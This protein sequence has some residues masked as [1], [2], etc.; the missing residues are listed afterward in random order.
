MVNITINFYIAS[1]KQF[2]C[3]GAIANQ[4]MTEFQWTAMPVKVDKQSSSW[5]Y[6][7]NL[8]IDLSTRN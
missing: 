6:K 3:V 4:Q 2:H 8:V 7:C 5:Q 1:R